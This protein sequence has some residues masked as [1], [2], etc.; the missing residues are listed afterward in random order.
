MDFDGVPAAPQQSFVTQ[1]YN[2][3]QISSGVDD[4]RKML[5]VPALLC[6]VPS[7]PDSQGLTLRLVSSETL[8]S[9]KI[10]QEVKAAIYHQRRRISSSYAKIFS[11]PGNFKIGRIF[12]SVS[13]PIGII[14]HRIIAT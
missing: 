2:N 5:C 11:N 3:A 12:E 13:S 1:G 9:S 8:F 14:L 10:V 7:V 4:G 6:S